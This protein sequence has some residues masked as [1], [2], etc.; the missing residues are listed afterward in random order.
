MLSLGR[1]LLV[2]ERL[3]DSLLEFLKSLLVHGRIF[4]CGKATRMIPID[5]AAEGVVTSSNAKNPESRVVTFASNKNNLVGNLDES[6]N[7]LSCVTVCL[8]FLMYSA[9]LTLNTCNCSTREV[10]LL[11]TGNCDCARK[12]S[13]K[14]EASQ[15][16]QKS[17]KEKY[18]NR[19]AKSRLPR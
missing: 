6:G 12:C 15:G 1:N 11:S 7:R 4:H 13:P 19:S 9:P 2:L 16:G 3:V 8:L 17:A 14:P 18:S 10:L 5:R